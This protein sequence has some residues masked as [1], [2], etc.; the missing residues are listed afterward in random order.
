MMD[1]S[2][3]GNSPTF[4]DDPWDDSDLSIVEENANFCSF[5][6]G[7]GNDRYD[8]EYWRDWLEKGAPNRT[9]WLETWLSN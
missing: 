9:K 8:I 1:S 5:W 2:I 4:S 6:W 7:V 3:L